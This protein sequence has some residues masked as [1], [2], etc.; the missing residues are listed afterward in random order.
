VG[1]GNESFLRNTPLDLR[2]SL[3]EVCGLCKR[4]RESCKLRMHFIT[5]ETMPVMAQLARWVSFDSLG[6]RAGGDKP[7]VRYLG[8]H[9]S[10]HLYS[11][12]RE[13]R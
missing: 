9:L 11:E 8:V 5:E 3:V 6:G 12:T 7:I 1:F 13:T 4:V 10:A 2:I